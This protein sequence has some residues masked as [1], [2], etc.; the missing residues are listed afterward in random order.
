MPKIPLG[1]NTYEAAIERMNYIFDNF[2]SIYLSFSAGK[3][4]TVMLHIAMEVAMQRNRK[5]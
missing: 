2:E 4:S 5:I 1:K 3:D